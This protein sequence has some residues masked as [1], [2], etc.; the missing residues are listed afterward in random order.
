MTPAEHKTY[1]LTTAA[2]QEERAGQLRSL[3]RSELNSADAC[4]RVARDLRREAD[5]ILLAE[6]VAD[7]PE[8]EEVA[9]SN[10]DMTRRDDRTRNLMAMWLD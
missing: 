1:L 10:V 3:A 9:P 6:V 5:A 2:Q 7:E 4:E 8:P